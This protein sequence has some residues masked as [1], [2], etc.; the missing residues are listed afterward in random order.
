MVNKPLI[1]SYFWGRVRLG[2]VGWLAMTDTLSPI[3]LVQWKM[4]KIWKVTTTFPWPFFF[5][6]PWSYGRKGNRFFE[7]CA[8]DYSAAY[9]IPG[10]HFAVKHFEPNN[11]MLPTFRP[12]FPRVMELSELS[13]W[14]EKPFQKQV[15]RIMINKNLSTKWSKNNQEYIPVVIST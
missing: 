11:D 7:D 6:E 4:A 12:C 15:L 3:I 8:F 9:H 1:R 13:T 14:H 10:T 2:G 5:T